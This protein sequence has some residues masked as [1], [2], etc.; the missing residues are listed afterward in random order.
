MTVLGDGE[1]TI[2]LND[3]WHPKGRL[4]DWVDDNIIQTWFP[5]GDSKV[6]EFI[7]Q[8][9]WCLTSCDDE[10]V[11]NVSNQVT[12]VEFNLNE[13][14]KLIWTT[15][16][17]GE[18]SLKDTYLTLSSS[19]DSPFW[20]DLVWFKY[21]ILRHSFISWLALQGRLKTRA[22]LMQWGLMSTAPCPFCEDTVETESHLFHGCNFA[23]QIWKGL[24]LNG[25]LQGSLQSLE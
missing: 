21:H 22:K 13:R 9:Q 11:L 1:D 16:K 23:S 25:I 24:L 5:N 2:M 15:S 20:C 19:N 14:D 8:G 10:A 4:V 12:S 17:N 7:D 18:F 3:L 6:A